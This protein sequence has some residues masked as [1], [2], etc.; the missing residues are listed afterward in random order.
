LLEQ[1]GAQADHDHPHH[2]RAQDPPFQDFGL[3]VGTNTE[4][5]ED[6]EEDEQ[7]VDTQRELDQIAGVV[8]QGRLGSFPPQHEQPEQVGDGN[9]SAAPAHCLPEGEHMGAAVEHPQVEDQEGHDQS[10]EAEPD[11]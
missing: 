11:R 5:G 10:G 3:G 4:V 9:K 6:E 8:L 1:Q 2:D 7:I